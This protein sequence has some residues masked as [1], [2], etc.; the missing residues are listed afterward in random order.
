MIGDALLVTGVVGLIALL[1]SEIAIGGK[2]K[3]YGGRKPLYAGAGICVRAWRT[4]RCF[5]KEY[6]ADV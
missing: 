2:N 5:Y 3:V 1:L 4:M 6:L